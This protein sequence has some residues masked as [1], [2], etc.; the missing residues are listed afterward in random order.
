[1]HHN[2]RQFIKRGV[3]VV[4]RAYPACDATT[5]SL[6]LLTANVERWIKTGIFC[7]RYRVNIDRPT[8]RCV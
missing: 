5:F 8:T 2:N 4:G 3:A 1:M 6:V 7:W